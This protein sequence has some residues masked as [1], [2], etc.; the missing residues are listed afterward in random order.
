[1]LENVLKVEPH[2]KLIFSHTIWCEQNIVGVTRAILSSTYALETSK[3]LIW[4]KKLGALLCFLFVLIEAKYSCDFPA[5]QMKQRKDRVSPEK[6][7]GKCA[8]HRL[9]VR[10]AKKR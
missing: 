9:C 7:R 10:Y 2:H 4:K 1:L 8:L 3:N 6:G 5:K